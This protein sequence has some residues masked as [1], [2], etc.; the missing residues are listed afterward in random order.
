MSQNLYKSS[1]SLFVYK[2]VIIHKLFAKIRAAIHENISIP[3]KGV[4]RGWAQGNRAPTIEM[5]FQIFK[6][7]F[8][9]DMSKMHY[10]SN[11]FSK[12]AKRQVP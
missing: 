1:A 10:F 5:M 6:L 3:S 9:G 8:S 7:N 12:I 4:A 11:K 2:S